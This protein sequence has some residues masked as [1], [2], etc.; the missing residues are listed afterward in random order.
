VL[1][2]IFSWPGVAIIA[3]LVLLSQIKNIIKRFIGSESGKAKVGPIEI[4][5]GK[6]AEQGQMAVNDLNRINYIMAESRRLE[7]E[8]TLGMT[9]MYK[10]F[11]MTV[12]SQ[13]QNDEMQKHISEL[14]A[15]TKSSANIQINSDR[16]TILPDRS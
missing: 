2:I 16:A 6:I 12:L 9:E 8:I 5:L 14:R 4:E 13:Q 7:L 3:M 11:G 10:S 15:L 1:Q